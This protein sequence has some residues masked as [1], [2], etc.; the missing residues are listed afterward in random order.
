[1]SEDCT[2]FQ[3]ENSVIYTAGH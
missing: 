2:F 3:K 1:M